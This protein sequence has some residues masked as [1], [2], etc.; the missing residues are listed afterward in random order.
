MGYL[1]RI[2]EH[3]FSK[4]S[5]AAFI[6]YVKEVFALAIEKI[7]G[8]DF[9]MAYQCEEN[10]HNNNYSKSPQYVLKKIFCEI[11][12]SI[13]H[14]FMDLGCGKGYVLTQASQYPFEKI[15][16]VEYTEELCEICKK[17]L[18]VLNLQDRIEVFN[19]DAKE[20]EDYG[21]YDVFY[22][23]NS[24]DE[25][26][27]SEVARKI[28]E[29]HFFGGGGGKPCKIYYLNPYQEERQRAITDAGFK[30]SKIITDPNEKY[31]DVNV[32]EVAGYEI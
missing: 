9:T 4:Q 29:T 7:Q 10:E 21:N 23:C 18:S 15:G 31:F 26:I 13:S 30:V 32:C 28:Y 25:T 17:N 16:G 22:L 6:R 1:K 19:C 5:R 27:L 11:E 3:P 8:L 14:S 2:T 20:Y 24:F 12:F